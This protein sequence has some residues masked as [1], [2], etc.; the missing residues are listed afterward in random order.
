[1]TSCPAERE[2]KTKIF[3][4]YLLQVVKSTLIEPRNP[5]K[6]DHVHALPLLSAMTTQRETVILVSALA[7]LAAL[8]PAFFSYSSKDAPSVNPLVQS[9]NPDPNMSSPLVTASKQIPIRA[10]VPYILA[11]PRAIIGIPSKPIV[12]AA[13]YLILIAAPLL[14]VLDAVFSLVRL[15]FRALAVVLHA[16]YP[17]Y[18]LCGAAVITGAVLGGLI[19]GLVKLA[20]LVQEVKQNRDEIDDHTEWRKQNQYTPE[21]ERYY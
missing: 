21:R 6:S 16:L 7:T 20:L 9:P 18:V 12:F 15:P 14:V 3:T 8:F 11:V 1:M 19:V 4:R 10:L 2:A 5:C 13:Y 17:I